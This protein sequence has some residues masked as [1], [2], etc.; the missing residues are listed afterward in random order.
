MCMAMSEMTI[1]WQKKTERIH[2]NYINW[3]KFAN[4]YFMHDKTFSHV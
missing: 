2:V 4:F 1:T 3:L